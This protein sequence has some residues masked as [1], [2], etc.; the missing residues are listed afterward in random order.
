MAKSLKALMEAKGFDKET[1]EAINEAWESRVSELRE[2]FAQ[3]YEHDKS[4]IVEAVDS[5]ISEKVEAEIAELAQDRSAL[6]DQR[7]KYR[8]AVREHAKLVDRFISETLAKEV[9][10]LRADRNALKEH[11][12]KLDRFVV[13]QL[14]EELREF[15]SDKKALVE[16]RVKI[17]KNS[18]KALAESKQRFVV[19]AARKIETIVTKVIESEIKRFRNDIKAARENDFG[20]QIFEAFAAEYSGTYLNQNAEMQK[21]QRT[22]SQIKRKLAEA[23]QQVSEK[24]KAVR[25]AESKLRA[26]QNRSARKQ[27]LSEL[28]GSLSR[29]KREIMVDLLES[30]PTEK[31]E[32]NFN[33]YLPSLLEGNVPQRRQPLKETR[34]RESLREH[35]G[36]RKAPAKA[37]GNPQDVIALD[38]IRKLAGLS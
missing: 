2:E 8:R 4:R 11:A 29:E 1:Q 21:V 19:E 25:L 23:E 13:K 10:E 16:E 32:E 24:D 38:N 5:F 28:T 31:L 22:L 26:E 30:V 20:R 27:K 36:D 33:K 18:R 37:A 34:S 15:H 14:S 3:R 7:V 35:T 6:V 12:G 17:A 9:R